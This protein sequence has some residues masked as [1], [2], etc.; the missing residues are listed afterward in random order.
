ME[1]KLH[2][3]MEARDIAALEKMMAERYFNSYEGAKRAMSKPMTIASL[4]A[5]SHKFLA[6]EKEQ[7]VR[8]ELNAV[9]VE[10]MARFQPN[11]IDDTTPQEQWVRVRRM[12]EKKDGEWLLT[13]QFWRVIQ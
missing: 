10:G 9:I 1:G 4:K 3:A 8:G 13:G 11:Q 5:G 7:Q 2:V 12:W 6:I